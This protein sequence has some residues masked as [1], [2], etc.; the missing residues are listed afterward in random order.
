VRAGLLAAGFFVAKGVSTGDKVETTYA[1][2]QA[3]VARRK[4]DDP[5]FSLLCQAWL[6][7]WERSQTRYPFGLPNDSESDLEYLI[8]NHS[9][10]IEM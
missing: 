3:A 1:L 7:R 9:Q 8:R 4:Q 5:N 6:G 10:F 2:T